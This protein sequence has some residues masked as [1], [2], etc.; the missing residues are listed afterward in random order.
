MRDLRHARVLSFLSHPLISIDS[1][2]VIRESL[3]SGLAQPFRS[4]RLDSVT[5]VLWYHVFDKIP[6]FEQV[7][8]QQVS[9]EAEVRQLLQR[10]KQRLGSSSLLRI[11]DD[12]L[13]RLTHGGRSV[14]LPPP[15]VEAGE[16]AAQAMISRPP[17]KPGYRVVMDVAIADGKPQV[18]SSWTATEQYRYHDGLLFDAPFDEFSALDL[19]TQQALAA[20][21]SPSHDITANIFADRIPESTRELAWQVLSAYAGT[22]M[23]RR[24]G[25]NTESAALRKSVLQTGSSIARSV[26]LDLEHVHGT[27]QLPTD[28]QQSWRANVECRPR[29]DSQMAG[30]LAALKPQS[31][32]FAPV[33]NDNAAL[34]VHTCFRMPDGTN[35]ILLALADRIRLLANDQSGRITPNTAIAIDLALQDIAKRSDIELLCKLGWT[36]ESHGVLYGGLLVPGSPQ[37]L[38]GLHSL[39]TSWPEKPGTPS[40][41]WFSTVDDFDV[42][43]VTLPDSLSRSIENQYSLHITS[44]YLAHV[45]SR[46]WFA[47]GSE[48]AVEIIRRCVSQC[49]ENSTAK[50]APLISATFDAEKWLSYPQD[51]KVGVGGYLTRLDNR[52]PKLPPPPPGVVFPRRTMPAPDIRTVLTFGG[53]QQ[54]EFTVNAGTGGIQSEITVGEAIANYCLARILDQRLRWVPEVLGE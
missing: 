48:S 7:R 44:V 32:L 50:R 10:R 9:D 34:T 1:G 47:A 3:P 11:T 16:L 6:K 54:C 45:D 52:V 8:F 43:A 14:F 21:I 39:A 49:R 17:D 18:E 24:T 4:D 36:E 51:D 30:Q 20:G 2:S 25:E 41:A 46:L 26:L 13:F 33:L 12:N 40:D 27:L 23:Q 31:S 28:E 22:Y 42:L 37:L 38:D 15:D 53:E 29:H 5:G 35:Q 19:P